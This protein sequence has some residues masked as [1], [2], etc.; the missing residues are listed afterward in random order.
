LAY[1]SQIVLTTKQKLGNVAI[2]TLCCSFIG[3]VYGYSIMKMKSA[4]DDVSEEIA[5]HEATMKAVRES[6]PP[7]VEEVRRAARLGAPRFCI[8]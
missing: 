1:N 4:G 6:L 3:S 8:G 5:L 7:P 2:A